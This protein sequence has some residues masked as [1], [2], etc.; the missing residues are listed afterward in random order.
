MTIV[1]ENDNK[2]RA[3]AAAVSVRRAS[4]TK[5][6]AERSLNYMQA[7]QQNGAKSETQSNRLKSI[8][9]PEA[10]PPKSQKS[11]NDN[12]TSTTKLVFLNSFLKD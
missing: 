11:A 9:M 12:K 2:S 10:D 1:P 5:S 4:E 3:S 8:T 7:R 6:N